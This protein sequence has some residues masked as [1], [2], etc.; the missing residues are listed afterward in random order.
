LKQLG[1][2]RFDELIAHI[3]ALADAGRKAGV[4]GDAVEFVTL[5]RQRLV[6]IHNYLEDLPPE[7]AP[8]ETIPAKA[9]S[10]TDD[11]MEKFGE[12]T[13]AARGAGLSATI[14]H[15]LHTARLRMRFNLRGSGSRRIVSRDEK[16]GS[17][18]LQG[19][20][21]TETVEV[22]DS[23]AYGVGVLAERGVPTNTVVHLTTQEEGRTRR[24]DCLVVYC[25]PHRFKYHVGLEIFA[26]RQ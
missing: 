25:E 17:A 22:V 3:D 10:D 9:V 12:V 14:T 4:D 2:T 26:I 20:E 16:T 8:Q 13:E 1:I 7:H 24:Y 11:L 23:S 19:P 5:I 15:Y 6:R 21:G 18:E